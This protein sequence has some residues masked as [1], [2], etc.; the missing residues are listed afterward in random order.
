MSAFCA[1]IGCSFGSTFKE[2]I[3]STLVPT[4]H[5]SIIATHSESFDATNFPAHGETFNA[6]F[7]AAL[8]PAD[9]ATLQRPNVSAHL[10]AHTSSSYI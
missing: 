5:V 3:G 2:T 6:A 10:S 7:N 1:S 8:P 4:K 9:G